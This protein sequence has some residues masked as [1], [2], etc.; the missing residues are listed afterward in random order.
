MVCNRLVGQPING[1]IIGGCR[2]AWSYL[3]K[4]EKEKPLSI[5]NANIYKEDIVDK[6]QAPN[7]SPLYRLYH[8]PLERSIGGFR[9]I[10]HI[11]EHLHRKLSFQTDIAESDERIEAL[12]AL[13]VLLLVD[14]EACCTAVYLKCVTLY[15][16]DELLGLAE[17]P[18]GDPIFRSSWLDMDVL[19]RSGE[20]PQGILTY[21]PRLIS[22]GYQG[23]LGS[24]SSSDPLSYRTSQS[25]QSGIFTWSG[26]VTRH[27]AEPHKKNLFLQSLC[28]DENSNMDST[29]HPFHENFHPQGQVS[30]KDR[31]ECLQSGVNCWTDFCK[32][33]Y[34]PRSLYEL[35]RSWTDDQKM[36]HYGNGV[37]VLSHS[38]HGEEMYERLRFF[39]EECDHIQG[40]QFIVDDS[41]GFSAIATGFLDDI[42]DEYVNTPVLLYAVRSPCA[43]VGGKSQK[44]SFSR[45]L[46]DAISF[47]RLSSH[48]KLMVPVGLPTLSKLSSALLIEDQKLFHSSAIYASAIHCASLPFRMKSPGPTAESVYTSGATD[49]SGMVQF[50]AGQGRQNM[51]N[52]LDLAMPVPPLTD[53]TNPSPILQSLC[54]L[55]PE[56]VE[57]DDDLHAT[58]ALNIYG[59]FSGG[60]R[61]TVGEIE[62]HI[63][64][65]YQNELRRP[66]FCHLSAA[67][68]PL[69]IPLPFPSIFSRRVGRRGELSECS[70]ISGDQ[71]RGSL[72][73]ESVPMAARLRSTSAV[74][75]FIERRLWSLRRYGLERG[76]PGVELLR[77]WGFGREDV[78]DMEEALAASVAK[79]DP[80]AYASEED[81]DSE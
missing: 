52:I 66:Q 20:T 62:Q 41:G 68:C 50:L 15:L 56:I 31:V 74:K 5:I 75:P 26:N 7:P 3:Q 39:V 59:S 43:Y 54:S 42:V 81:L 35:H 19:Y 21:C 36:D 70:L 78:E 49:M 2:R 12:E 30:D 57:H 38:L 34:H 32:V 27:M 18:Q 22:V 72:D 80:Q 67:S 44:E 11:A 77:S 63:N 58:E 33:Q 4:K 24:L 69:P 47:G 13:G 1:R 9:P 61:A 51:I 48:S 16:K 23:T 8:V 65:A 73:V 10:L 28:E 29:D 25:D 37:D 40:I 46:H 55:T 45:A 79:L 17:E 76:A 53:Q 14:L 60:R 64:D 71:P 6:H